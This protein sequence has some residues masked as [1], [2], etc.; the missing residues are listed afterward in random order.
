MLVKGYIEKNLK[1]LGSLY[2]RAE[3]QRKAAYYSK[4][5]VIELCGWIE[6]S[7]DDI[8]K[9][10]AK[11]ELR[12]KSNYDDFISR[13]AN[14]YGFTYDSHIKKI[15]MF[16]AGIKGCE[17]F[18]KRYNKNGNLEI[19]KGM[20][21]SLK[22]SRDGFAHTFIR[23]N[24]TAQFQSPSNTLRQ[25]LMLRPLIEDIEKTTKKIV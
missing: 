12:V 6:E 10:I 4:L 13:V 23:K 11:N 21:S 20:L 18:E 7:V 15:I 25:Y 17:L 22:G 19:L 5:A 14:V 2:D 24:L 1:D 16:L 9:R 8:F 3:S